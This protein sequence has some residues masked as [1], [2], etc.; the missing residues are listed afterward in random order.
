[1]YE[2]E[3]AKERYEEGQAIFFELMEPMPISLCMI[4]GNEEA[5]IFELPGKRQNRL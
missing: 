3:N 5:V 4:C 2:Q 1:V